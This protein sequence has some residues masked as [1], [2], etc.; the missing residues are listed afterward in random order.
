MRDVK[1][2]LGILVILSLVFCGCN[3]KNEAVVKGGSTTEIVDKIEADLAI[4]GTK[5][6][7]RKNARIIGKV[8]KVLPNTKADKKLKHCDVNP[9]R[10]LVEVMALPQSGS[11]YH[12]QY[13]ETDK[14]E[15]QFLYTIE[16]THQ[17]F[18][19]LYKPLVG[20]SSGSFFEAELFELEPGQYRVQLYNKKN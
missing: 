16:A 6:S 4:D 12:G 13:N 20:L 7:S 5:E 2:L 9:C 15:V 3:R 1:H 8:V 17:L 11:N 19:Q 10:A 18:P 14:I